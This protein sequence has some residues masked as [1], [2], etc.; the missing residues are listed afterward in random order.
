MRAWACCDRD[1]EAR[2]FE[3]VSNASK[4]SALSWQFG[5]RENSLGR[6]KRRKLADFS[7]F[8]R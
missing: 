2:L 7:M 3:L 8:S 1:T 6:Q 4:A 5:P